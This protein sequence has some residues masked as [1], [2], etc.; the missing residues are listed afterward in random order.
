MIYLALLDNRSFGSVIFL[1]FLKINQSVPF[2]MW[3]SMAE[4]MKNLQVLSIQG[5]RVLCAGLPWLIF[6]WL[7]VIETGSGKLK[8][9]K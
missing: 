7:H 3:I 8:G 4:E 5:L 1:T 6:F 2:W 9:K